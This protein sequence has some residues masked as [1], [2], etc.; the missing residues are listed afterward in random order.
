MGF[1]H[2]SGGNRWVCSKNNQM[3]YA[4]LASK[5]PPVM[6]YPYMTASW[7]WNIAVAFDIRTIHQIGGESGAARETGKEV[8]AAKCDYSIND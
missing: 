7:L 4:S 5:N 2:G 8:G 6:E 3:L 1:I